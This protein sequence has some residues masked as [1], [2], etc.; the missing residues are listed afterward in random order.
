MCNISPKASSNDAMPSGEVHRVEFRF[1]DFS[2]V[3]QNALL[4]ER[5][6]HTI[7]CVLLHCWTHI[8]MFDDGVL[9]LLLI[10]SS[11]GY[12]NLLVDSWLPLLGFIYSWVE[13][14]HV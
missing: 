5:I 3:I 8:C 4:L 10:D 1:D 14:C 6:S 13:G 2:N 7:N 9:G 12:A 11:M